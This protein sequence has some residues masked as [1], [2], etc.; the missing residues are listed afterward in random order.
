MKCK[1]YFRDIHLWLSL[2]AGIIISVICLT[3]AILV[4]KEEFLAWGGYENIRESPLMFVMKLHR[5]LLDDTRTWGKMIV[6]IS[7]LFFIFILITGLTVYWPKK[8]K[9][10][11][12]TVCNDRGAYRWY[13]D[14]HCV[15]GL[16]AALI[17]LV[18]ALTGLL[19]SFQ[20]CRDVVSWVT[21][22]EIKR[23]APIWKTIRALHFGTYAGW[24][25]KLL[26]FVAAMIGAILPLTG[27]WLYWKKLKNRKV[28][29]KAKNRSLR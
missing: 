1:K 18:C 16:Y 3:G 24:F 25:S 14:V 4:F 2:P 27:Y 15:L 6:G 20:W 17:L 11:H 29:H 19:W 5:W 23:G 9:R 7:T 22:E 10:A 8:W 12:L 21:G 28:A 26:T 13:R